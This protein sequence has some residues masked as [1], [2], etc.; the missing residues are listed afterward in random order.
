LLVD[1]GRY[2]DKV[3]YKQFKTSKMYKNK[4]Y[5]MKKGLPSWQ[6]RFNRLVVTSLEA[7]DRHCYVQTQQW[8][9]FVYPLLPLEKQ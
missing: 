8:D 7:Q 2:L 4:A 1:L 3:K 6:Q 5:L 9:A